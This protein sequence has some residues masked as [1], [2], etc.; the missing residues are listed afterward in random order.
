MVVSD[1]VATAGDERFLDCEGTDRRLWHGKTK[2][3][4]KIEAVI[5]LPEGMTSFVMG[6]HQ[7]PSSTL[8]G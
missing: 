8:L 4:K 5:V 1:L 3:K 2:E 7:R 6:F